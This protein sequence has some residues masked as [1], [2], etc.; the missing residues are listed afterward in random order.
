MRAA[1]GGD[2]WNRVGETIAYGRIRVAGLSGIARVDTDLVHGRYARYF[3]V[4][5]MG[6]SAEVYDVLR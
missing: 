1:I 2:A 5:G 6:S 4:Y 3:N